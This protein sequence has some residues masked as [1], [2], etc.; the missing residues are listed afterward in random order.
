LL[1]IFDSA[2]I[3]EKTD[4]TEIVGGE[5]W[6]TLEAHSSLSLIRPSQQCNLEQA[7]IPAP[8]RWIGQNSTAISMWA[9]SESATS[10]IHQTQM[11]LLAK[12]EKLPLLP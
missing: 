3:E 11:H 1:A 8:D 2:G 5:Q 10:I 12:R 7:R 9:S 4:I 6:T